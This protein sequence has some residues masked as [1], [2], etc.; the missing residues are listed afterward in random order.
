MTPAGLELGLG[1]IERR[2]LFAF[3]LLAVSSVLVLSGAALIGVDRGVQVAQQAD[4]EEFAGAAVNAAADAFRQGG[5][6]DRAD[7]S[8]AIAIAAAA[9]ARLAVLYADGTTIQTSGNGGGSPNGEGMGEGMGHGAVMAG[10][11]VVDVAWSWIAVA[12]AVALVVALG[13]SWL[14]TRLVQG[15]AWPWCAKSCAATAGPSR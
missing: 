6:W 8:R 11:R 13:A 7:L 14:V 10:T 4:R 5:G 2:L 12:A 3:V 1:P 9:S 15:S